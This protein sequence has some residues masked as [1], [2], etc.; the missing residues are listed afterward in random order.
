MNGVVIVQSV[1]V[2]EVSKCNMEVTEVCVV[3]G[4]K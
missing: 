4:E 1:E 2:A 3:S